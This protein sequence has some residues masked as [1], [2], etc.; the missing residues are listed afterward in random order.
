[1]STYLAKIMFSD[2]IDHF[3]GMDEESA[4]EIKKVYDIVA[5]SVIC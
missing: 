4:A 5:K 1:M 2:F 3:S